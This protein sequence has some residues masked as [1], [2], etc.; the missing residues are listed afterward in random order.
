MFTIPSI[1]VSHINIIR[2][3]SIFPSKN[4]QYEPVSKTNPNKI[5]PLNIE[6][7]DNEVVTCTNSHPA[8]RNNNY[9]NDGYSVGV[10]SVHGCV[11]KAHHVYKTHGYESQY[12]SAISN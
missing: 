8:N 4:E 1:L 9:N 10:P 5:F 3:I 2:I 11:T 6:L 7:I 12:F